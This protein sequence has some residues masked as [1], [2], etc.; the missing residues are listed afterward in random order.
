MRSELLPRV[1]DVP[2][3][4]EKKLL[5]VATDGLSGPFV[6]LIGWLTE[7]ARP[8]TRRALSRAAA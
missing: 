2:A 3:G 7:R 5:S 8:V 4:R 1:D 6:G